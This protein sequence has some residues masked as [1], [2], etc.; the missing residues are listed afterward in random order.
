MDNPG[1]SEILTTLLQNQTMEL[2][3][4][5]NSQSER[6]RTALEEQSRRQTALL[7]RTHQSR[8]QFLIAQKDEEVAAAARRGAE[9]RE[10]LDRTE[11]EKERWRRVA[12][13]NEARIG[14]LRMSCGG[15]NRRRCCVVMVP[16]RH[17]CSCRECEPQ[18]ESCPV[19]KTVKKAA[20]DA[21]L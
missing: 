1:G 2:D 18:L 6:L 17:L 15:C 3:L 11:M 4:F 20:I 10:C 5:I 7:L 13:E 19:C 21:F 8:I 9:L 16:C 12:Q 14:R